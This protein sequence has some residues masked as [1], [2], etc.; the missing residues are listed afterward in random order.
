VPRRA[1]SWASISWIEDARWGVR[2][3]PAND[4]DLAYVFLTWPRPAKRQLI[5]DWAERLGARVAREA[6]PDSS[7]TSGGMTN[8]MPLICVWIAGNHRG[9]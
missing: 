8:M 9:A 7:K 6:R 4:Q 3:M 5:L 1:Y 2:I